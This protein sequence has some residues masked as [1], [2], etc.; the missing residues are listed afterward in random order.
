MNLFQNRK[1]LLKRQHLYC[2]ILIRY[3]RRRRRPSRDLLR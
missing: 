1:R 2:L 3:I